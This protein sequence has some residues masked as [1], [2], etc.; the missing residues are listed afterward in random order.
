E[1]RPQRRAGRE[2]QAQVR[3]HRDRAS[4]GAPL[5]RRVHRRFAVLTRADQ[6]ECMAALPQ[7]TNSAFDGQRHAVE[8]G[9]KRL[10]HVSN[11]HGYLS[12]KGGPS[13]S[14][15]DVPSARAGVRSCFL[16]PRGSKKQD[17]TPMRARDPNAGT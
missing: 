14:A 10:G 7:M 15:I 5:V 13:N 4:E 17:L 1:A 11:A 8:L 3:V 2:A 6:L 12:A 16:L 9:G